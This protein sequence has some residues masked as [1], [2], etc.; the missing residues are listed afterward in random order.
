[1]RQVIE[2]LPDR[3]GKAIA[4]ASVGRGRPL[5]CD[6]GFISHLEVQ[7]EYPPYRRFFE[8]LA[9]SHRVIRF[10]M[11]GIGLGDSTGEVVEFDQD[12]AV[13]EDVIDGLRLD[14]VDLFGASQAA[15]VMIA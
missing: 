8:V 4:Y 7:W 12:V 10:D 15:A 11:P 6:T 13:L 14:S 2:F 9:T 3:N 5:V 1:M